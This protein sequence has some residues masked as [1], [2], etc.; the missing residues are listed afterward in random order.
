MGIGFVST[1]WIG[2]T[3]HFGYC[4]LS[5]GIVIGVLLGAKH[6]SKKTELSCIVILAIMTFTSLLIWLKAFML[7]HPLDSKIVQIL[8]RLNIHNL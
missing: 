8:M 4:Y 1:M 6:S 3:K 5:L 2:L 7:Y